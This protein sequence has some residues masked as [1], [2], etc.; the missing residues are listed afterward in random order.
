ML[1][2]VHSTAARI[3]PPELIQVVLKGTIIVRSSLVNT[4]LDAFRAYD[5][6]F[7]TI[8]IWDVA[9]CYVQEYECRCGMLCFVHQQSCKLSRRR[10][11]IN[12]TYL[13]SHESFGG[14]ESARQLYSICRGDVT[15]AIA[16]T[17]KVR[18]LRRDP[19]K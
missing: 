2:D 9:Q 3:W 4:F 11:V 16:T 19:T 12:N 14:V 10:F 1:V 5:I 15:K 6:V 17:A 7:V 13:C 8:F 18:V